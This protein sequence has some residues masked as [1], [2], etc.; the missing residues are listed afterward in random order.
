M[1]KRAIRIIFPGRTYYEALVINKC[2]RLDIRCMKFCIKSLRKIIT[3][4]P[5]KEHVLEIR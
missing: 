4:G 2:E 1:P 3:Q 5:L